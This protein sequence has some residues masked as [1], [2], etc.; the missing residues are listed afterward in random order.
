VFFALQA[1]A[2]EPVF[3]LPSGEYDFRL[4]DAE[5]EQEFAYPARVSIQGVH[6]KVVITTDG[7]PFHRD[8]V[9]ADGT[10]R[11]HQSSGQWFIAQSPEDFDAEDVGG[12]SG[13]P[14]TIDSERRVIWYC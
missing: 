7:G 10:I 14:R 12:C 13:G 2:A 3:P 4:I 9:F 8:Q 5:Y 11:W 6:I 1:A